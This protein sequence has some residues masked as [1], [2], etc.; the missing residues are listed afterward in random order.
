MGSFDVRPGGPHLVDLDRRGL[1][2]IRFRTAH[3]P[4]ALVVNEEQGPSSVTTTVRAGGDPVPACGVEAAGV[5]DVG[6]LGGHDGLLGVSSICNHPIADRFARQPLS[7]GPKDKTPT[8]N[9]R[10]DMY[11]ERAR[12]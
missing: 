5:A 6:G 1:D 9:Q 10:L 3:K 4:A 11:T 7:R 12:M 8:L 2:L